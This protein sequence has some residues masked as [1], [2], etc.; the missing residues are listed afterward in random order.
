MPRAIRPT[1]HRLSAW[2]S[3]FFQHRRCKDGQCEAEVQ[4][5][6]GFITKRGEISLAESDEGIFKVLILKRLSTNAVG[7][8]LVHDDLRWD[9]VQVAKWMQNL[10]SREAV[11]RLC[12][13][14]TQKEP[15]RS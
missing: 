3:C 5:D 15:W 7:Y 8:V 6:F 11:R 10:D 4:A 14:R 2:K 1:L 9:R 13:I 12:C